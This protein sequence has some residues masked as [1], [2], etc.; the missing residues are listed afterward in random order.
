MRQSYLA[1]LLFLLLFVCAGFTGAFAQ[2]GSVSGR[3]VDEK[4]GGL[5]GVTVLIEGTSLGNSTNSD[6]TYSIQNIPAGPRTLVVSFVGYTTGRIPVT[7]TAGQNTAVATTI[8]N[9][10]T[11]LLNEAVVIGYGTQRKQDLTGAVE[12][13][14]EKQFVKGQV[15]NP[16]QLVQGKVAGLQITTG[17]GAPGTASA[18]RIRGGSS[19]SASNDPLIVIDGVPVD[20]RALG[21]TPNRESVVNPLSLIN[22]ND[23]ESISVLKDASATAIYGSRASNGVILVTTKRGMQGEK[24]RVAVS[25]QNSVSEVYRLAEVLNADEFRAVVQAR[26]NAGQEAL[27]GAD[28]TNWQEAI[29]RTAQTTDNTV[30]V[31]G[32]AGKVPY[33]VSAGYLDQEGLLKFNDLK[34]YTGS[35]GLTPVLLDGDLRIDLNA[36]GAWIDNN[37][38][39]QDAV[40][41]AVLYDPTRPIRAAE[42]QY[43]RYGNYFEFLDNGG[44]V[45]TLGPRNPVSL[46]EQTRRR[47]TIKR[48]IGNIQF[49][50]KL[51]FVEGLG[52]NLNLGY[53]VQFINGTTFAPATSGSLN[54]GRAG[55]NEQYRQENRN[56]L[57]DAL[58]KYNRQ[59]GSGKFDILGGYSYQD[60][61]YR[62][63]VFDSRLE[64]GS[65]FQQP[66]D[67][68]ISGLDYFNP[69][70]NIQSFFGRANYNIS[71]KYL[72][73]ATFRADGVSRF[74][75]DKRWG[76]FPAGAFAW[77]IKGEEFLKNST[78]VSD[79]KLRLGYGQTGQQDIG[80][81][82][83]GYLATYV[84]SRNNAQY[85]LGN[86][87][88][89]TQR[90]GFYNEN[91][92]WETTTTYNLGLDYG[93]IDGRVYGSV[94]VYRRN[95]RD[96][97]NFI[98]VASLVNLSNGG[99]FNIGSLRNEGVEVVVNTDVVRGEKLNWTLN[100][101]ASYNKNEVTELIRG[102]DP[103][104]VGFETGSIDGGVGN[105]IQ[106]N[107]VGFP[108]QSFLVYQ[109]VYGADGKPL[110]GVVVD[111]NGDGIINNLDRYRYKSPRPDYV[112]GFGSNLTYGK[113]NLAFTF[114]SN[115]NN[116]VYNNTRSAQGVFIQNSNTFV[117]NFNR[118]VLDNNFTSGNTQVLQSDYFI[119][120]AS[121]LRMENL[122]VGYNFGNIYKERA[123][124]NLSFAVQN[125][126]VVTDY[127]GI[128]PEV[129]GFGNTLG[130]V[131]QTFG[132]DRTIYPRPRTYTVGLSIGL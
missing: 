87:F 94:D 109:Q 12:Q 101:N 93:F 106:V 81:N 104:F 97:L 67:R 27:V 15:T 64:D 38:S 82:Y 34:R 4:N 6:G 32:A 22:P 49:D 57:L 71:D 20:N 92:T 85:Q 55:L 98:N 72:F 66:A 39:N 70:Y 110:D 60:F 45:N 78:A 17:A 102:D 58:L 21:G 107:T 130:S 47:S 62:D 119:E 37:F 127:K 74:A 73:T 1:K 24:M 29:Y 122:T 54:G 52:A 3:V 79:L 80:S 48:S 112:L 40:S 128:D 108:A 105:N 19:L 96:L 44:S 41:N 63:Y 26:G 89:N 11:T 121:F 18:I 69:G 120:N 75:S 23:I 86:Q 30:S 33:R 114:R 59:F 113:A 123:N 42:P 88:V 132:I 16:E 68:P 115:L 13:I 83:Y 25:S 90:P 61:K 131:T 116:Y 8:L 76:Y 129:V 100:A 77:R 124:L 56:K 43:T 50:Y 7:I 9:E 2:T 5:P 36:K 10:N 28:N 99:F 65:I 117:P 125:L 35:I 14:N 53:D 51:P 46:I 111:R 126:F 95:T 31:T 91:L 84:P 118:E 103:S